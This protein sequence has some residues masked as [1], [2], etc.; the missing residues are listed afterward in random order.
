MLASEMS[1]FAA[2]PVPVYAY[3][4]VQGREFGL[5]DSIYQTNQAISYIYLSQQMILE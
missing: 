4:F 2:G 3:S 1:R 5:P